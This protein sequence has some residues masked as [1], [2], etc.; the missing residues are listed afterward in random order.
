MPKE[1]IIAAMAAAGYSFDDIDSYDDWLVFNGDYC[2]K[3]EFSSWN[4]V[5]DWLE[6]VV[7]DDPEISDKVEKILHPERF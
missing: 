2:T 5:Q 4:D 3:M 6:N 7:F 1:T